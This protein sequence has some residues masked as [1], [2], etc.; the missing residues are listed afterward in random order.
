MSKLLPFW[1]L[2]VF[3]CTASAVRAQDAGTLNL[4]LVNQRIN[5][6]KANGAEDS[7]E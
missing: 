7:D 2:L 1:L 4:D 5:T 6:L 3:A